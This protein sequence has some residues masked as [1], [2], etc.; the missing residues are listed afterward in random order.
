ML[1][2]SVEVETEVVEVE[3]EGAQSAQACDRYTFVYQGNEGKKFPLLAGKSVL[4]SDCSRDI[5]ACTE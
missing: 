3:S 4:L 1:N 5:Q 2:D